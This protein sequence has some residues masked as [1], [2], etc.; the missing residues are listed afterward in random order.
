MVN[1]KKDVS[2]FIDNCKECQRNHPV[3]IFDHPARSLEVSELFNKV[4]IDLIFG[5][6]VSEDGYCGIL[7]IV[8]SISK[9]PMAFPIKTKSS[10]EIARLF[11]FIS[12][13]GPPKV[14]F[15]DQGSEFKGIVSEMNKLIGIDHI[16]TAAY[17]PRC[18]GLAERMNQT[19]GEIL[20]KYCVK[21]PKDWPKWLPFILMCY[22]SRKNSTTG[23]TP[24]FIMFGR[25]R[26]KFS[27]LFY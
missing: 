13:F 27:S 19:I 17:N 9:Y 23:F 18:N 20:R 3:K 21:N 24:E 15:S 22:R 12:I 16:V 25:E 14:F 26:N 4:H 1:I 7:L 8:E 5:L 10:P 11:E 6:P 2:N